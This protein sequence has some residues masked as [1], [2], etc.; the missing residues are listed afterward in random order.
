[1][2]IDA[3]KVVVT[4]ARDFAGKYAMFVISILTALALE[5]VGQNCIT[6][7]SPARRASRSTRNCAPTWPRSGW[8]MPTMKSN[9]P[10]WTRWPSRWPRTSR[11]SCRTPRSCAISTR[12]PTA[13]STSACK[14]QRCAAKRG[15]WRSPTSRPAICRPMPWAAIRKRIHACATTRSAC[16]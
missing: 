14:R 10:N 2:H 1:M 8:S 6:T 15:T 9:T 16:H 12:P 11:P 3:P 7:K 5:H 4:S 13:S